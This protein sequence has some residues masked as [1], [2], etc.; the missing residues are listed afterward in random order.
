MI[1]RYHPSRW[2]ALMRNKKGDAAQPCLK[3]AA[4]TLA[5]D[6]PRQVVE[7]QS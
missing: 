6:F 2:V 7:A 1:V 3:A 5:S 4:R